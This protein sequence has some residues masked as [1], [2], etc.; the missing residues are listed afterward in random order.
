MT[1]FTKQQFLSFAAC[2]LRIAQDIARANGVSLPIVQLW[3][4]QAVKA[5]AK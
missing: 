3:S 4:A 1:N 2:G 5:G